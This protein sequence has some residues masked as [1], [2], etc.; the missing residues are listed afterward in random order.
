MSADAEKAKSALFEFLS[1]MKEWN[2]KFVPLVKQSGLAANSGQAETELRPIYEKYL[3]TADQGA[4]IF[5]VGY[6]PQYDPDAEKVV[7]IESPN[8]RKVVFETLWT[9]PHDPSSIQQH[10]Y[11][12]INKSGE[13]RLHKEEFHVG[14]KWR[15]M[16]FFTKPAKKATKTGVGSTRGSL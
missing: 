9:H 11:T 2:N 14:N 16:F 8:A 4:L 15:R 6:P 3:A 10:R 5:S 12:M 1:A 7:S 13:W